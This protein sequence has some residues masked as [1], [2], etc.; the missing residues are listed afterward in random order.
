[1]REYVTM[2]G[3]NTTVEKIWN[4]YTKKYLIMFEK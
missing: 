4:V 1:M 3:T 2:K